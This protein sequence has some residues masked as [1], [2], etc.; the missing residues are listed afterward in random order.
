MV[1]NWDKFFKVLRGTLNSSPE[2]KYAENQSMKY[3]NYA[4]K[5][6]IQVVFHMAPVPNV[7]CAHI[8]LG[9]DLGNKQLQQCTLE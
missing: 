5:N 7:D 3:E 6:P 2:L 4:A 1:L 9:N 8:S